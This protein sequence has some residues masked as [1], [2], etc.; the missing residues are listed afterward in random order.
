MQQGSLLCGGGPF[1]FLTPVFCG[2]QLYAVAESADDQK[3]LIL[4]VFSRIIE[5]LL[6]PLRALA[7]ISHYNSKPL[8]SP[9]CAWREAK[10]KDLTTKF[11]T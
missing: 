6:G 4:L 2:R 3:G 8:A 1:L 10:P 5:G 7:R 11:F 9:P